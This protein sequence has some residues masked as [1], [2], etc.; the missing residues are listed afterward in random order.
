MKTVGPTTNTNPASNTAST[1]LMFESHRMP[2]ATPDTADNTNATVR[3]VMM[4]IRTVLPVSLT[5]ATICRPLRI[6]SAPSPSEAAEPKRVAKIANMSI[7]LP[8]MPL[9]R[10]PSSG[11]NAEL[12]S[13]I[14]PLRYTP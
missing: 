5:P 6:C 10:L 14:R 12:I 3:I 2:R 7:T 1:M 4:T 13:C 11:S 8:P 9:A